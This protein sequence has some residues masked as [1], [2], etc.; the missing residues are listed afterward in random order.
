[1]FNYR[2]LCK[3][4]LFN[5][6][7][8]FL[9]VFGVF[10]AFVFFVFISLLFILFVT[11]HRKTNLLVNLYWDNKYSDLYLVHKNFHAK[12]CMFTIPDWN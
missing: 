11:V 4:L 7:I 3:P 2:C 1:M 5:A 12:P 8:I 9:C 10:L 6:V